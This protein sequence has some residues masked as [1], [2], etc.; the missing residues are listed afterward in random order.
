M[1]VQVTIKVTTTHIE[2]LEGDDAVWAQE[3][4]V[5]FAK[6]RLGGVF[7]EDR[8]TSTENRLFFVDRKGAPCGNM[9]ITVCDK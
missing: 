2:T 9:V 1:S 8:N 6:N 4:P 5:S 3:D 7:S